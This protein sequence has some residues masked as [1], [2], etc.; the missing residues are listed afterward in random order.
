MSSSSPTGTVT[1][2][3]LRIASVRDTTA[4]VRQ[5]TA[6]VTI[7]LPLTP[8]L[9]APPVDSTAVPATCDSMEEAA[10]ILASDIH[11]EI[12]VPITTGQT[13]SD[14]ATTMICRGG[15]PLTA[16]RV[17]HFQVGG[18][19]STSDSSLADI[20]RQSALTISGSGT[21]GSRRITVRGEG[22]SATRF[23]YDL[24]RGRLLESEGQSVLRLAFETIQQTEQV[25]QHSTS[26]IRIRPIK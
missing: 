21:Q 7:Q 18:V 14:S 9:I 23:T 19:R 12:P 5:L 1:V 4:P 17:S 3:S 2:D 13:W 20:D 8:V 26:R 11:M 24:R 16:T 25:V 6:P 22:T 10:R 15:I